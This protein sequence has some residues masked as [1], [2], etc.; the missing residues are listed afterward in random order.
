MTPTSTYQLLSV[1]QALELQHLAGHG[2]YLPS[3]N[4]E[5][6]GGDRQKDA[7]GQS[8]ERCKPCKSL[9]PRQWAPSAPGSRW[10]G[11]STEPEQWYVQ[12]A[13]FKGVLA[14]RSMQ[15]ITLSP[16]GKYQTTGSMERTDLVYSI[17]PRLW[18]KDSHDS[19]FQA[20]I[21]SPS[22]RALGQACVAR[23]SRLQ[24]TTDAA[25]S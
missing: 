22:S 10:G 3:R 11:Y 13:K 12:R 2:H 6:N 16:V 23:T 8:T 9:A 18:Y 4:S 19:R 17:G 5:S 15:A 14:L 25:S 24:H 20:I 21:R 1:H 7:L